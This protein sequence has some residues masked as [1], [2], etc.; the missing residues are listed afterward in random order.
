MSKHCGA[1]INR[2][3]EE[4]RVRRAV[5]MS[6]REHERENRRGREHLRQSKSESDS[7]NQ[8]WK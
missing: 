3:W 6:G 1:E 2:M 5:S 4:L 7:E 8:E